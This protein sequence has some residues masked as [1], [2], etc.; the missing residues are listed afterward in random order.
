MSRKTV[1]LSLVSGLS[2]MALSACSTVD[3]G[4]VPVAPPPPAPLTGTP[5]DA[6]LDLSVTSQ[7]PR[8]ARPVHYDIAIAPDAQAMTFA[9]TAHVDV[10]IYET[11]DALVLN[12]LDLAFSNA[13]LTPLAGGTAAP[14]TITLDEAA[15]TA[16]FKTA[17]PVTPGR[18]RLSTTYTG[19]INTQANGLFALDYKAPDGSDKRGLF[20]Q[21]EAPDARRFVPSFDEPSYKA[22]FALTATVPGDQMAVSNMPVKT[23]TM[24]A[25]G[26]KTVA[27][28]TSVKM[29]SYLLFFSMGDFER[30][31]KK[32]PDGIDVGIVAPRGSGE[33]ARFALDGLAEL[34][35]YYRDYFGVGYPLP[36][37]DNV[38]GPGQ[39]QFFGAMENWGA[40]FTFERILMVDPAITSEALRQNTYSTQ[41]HE[42]AHQWFGNLVT[43]A[44]WD[45]LWLNEGFASWMETKATDHFHPEW[46]PLLGRVGGRDG[47]MG[48]DAY[49]TTHAIVQKIST[50][51]ETNQ[52]FDTITY[53]KGE[54]VISML[55]AYAGA[56][57]WQKGIQNYM[58]KHA[59][60]NTRTDDLWNAVE[61]AGAPGLTAI[62][63]DY[64]TQAGIP[65]IR[66]QNATCTN[67]QTSLALSQSEY[68][69]DRG[70]A[71]NT[72]ATRWK[73]PVLA[74]VSG[75][76]PVRQIVDGGAGTMTLPGCGTVVINSGQ[77][78]YYR[79][80]YTPAMLTAL[81]G[82]FGT[83]PAI[84]QL[85]LLSDQFALSS[86]GY[87]PMASAL[88]LLA[89]VPA[90]AND[91]V[92]GQ[93]AGLYA[94]LFGVFES[95]A[96]TQAKVAAM[97]Q[98]R[99]SPLLGKLGFTPRA[100]DTAGAVTLRPQLIATLGRMRDPAVMTE[101]RRLFAALDSNPK[102]LDGPLK[103]TWMGIIARNAT[104]AEWDKL[105]RI[106]STSTSNLERNTTY[107]LLGAAKDPKLA[108]AALALA[109]TDEPG[110]TTSAAIISAVAR[111]HADKTVDFVLANQTKV[112]ALVDTSGRARYIA[113]LAAASDSPAMIGKLQGIAAKLPADTRKPFDQ[114]IG[115]LQ[116]KFAKEPRIRSETK[117][118]LAAR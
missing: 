36:K 103:T 83:V 104:R 91:K 56:D 70:G 68:A 21:F 95:D 78:G 112:D 31:S 80:L 87:Q 113:R 77:A 44:W 99:L 20:T 93:S 26:R 90:G 82:S 43:M 55:E 98:A 59:Y 51:E 1:T 29:S 92:T 101:A 5:L 52:A 30:L 116:D 60:G 63:R 34:M 3:Y 107:V 13:T 100:G 24:L 109:L 73:V 35:P 45:D 111:N 106:A 8:T 58:A 48:L 9:A 6:P 22:T 84:D 64:T 71:A 105:R 4:G 89:A 114:V 88:N 16:T 23:E 94:T 14:A 118:W 37:L 7:L 61:A 46:E 53:E 40:I 11:T 74:S 66:V 108:D 10:E 86:D 75:K 41:A 69:A 50:V 97:A 18:Y 115:I 42:V 32:S 72:L 102:A 39:S 79:T 47:A 85:G 62:A 96:P 17:A 33:K 19:I 28:D 76:A 25:D 65:L 54:A 15:Q 49:A 117:A 38:T 2:L 67:G 81:A 110:K 12:A 27:F 57:V